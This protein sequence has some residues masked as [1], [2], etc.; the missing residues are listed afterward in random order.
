MAVGA[1]AASVPAAQID[2]VKRVCRDTMGL[3]APN[4]DYVACVDSLTGSLAEAAT[5]RAQ[6][7][8]DVAGQSACG[9]QGLKPDTPDYAMC[10]LNYRDKTLGTRP[11]HVAS[12]QNPID[13]TGGN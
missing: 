4:T 5:N 13:I 9:Q 8:A 6:A 1:H 11:A 3:A 12:A 10:V 7:A 2:T